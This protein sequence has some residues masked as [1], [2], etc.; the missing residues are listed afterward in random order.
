MAP[1]Q[2]LFISI[3]ACRFASCQNPIQHDA[4][5]QHNAIRRMRSTWALRSLCA[6]TATEPGPL[7]QGYFVRVFELSIS[8]KHDRWHAQ[9]LCPRPDRCVCSPTSA[10]C[11]SGQTGVPHL[12]ERK[13]E[14]KCRVS[15]SY[16]T[17][18]KHTWNL[19]AAGTEV[20]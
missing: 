5:D 16:S 4:W 10:A 18:I 1:V 9:L 14:T 13:P 8:S 19:Q 12:A 7:G 15:I 2:V 17:Y 11:S 6:N 3:H 20:N